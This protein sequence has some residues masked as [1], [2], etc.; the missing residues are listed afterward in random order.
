MRTWVIIFFV[1]LVVQLFGQGLGFDFRRI[2]ST[3]G[4]PSDNM[5]YILTDSDGYLWLQGGKGLCRFDGYHFLSLPQKWPVSEGLT[6]DDAGNIVCAVGVSGLFRLY[7]KTMRLDTLLAGDV[8]NESRV[9]DHFYNPIFYKKEGSIWTATEGHLRQTVLESGKM[10]LFPFDFGDEVWHQS[11][12]LLHDGTLYFAAWSG[13]FRYSGSGK[14]V[15]EASFL[16][17][18]LS[19]V[20]SGGGAIWVASS[21]GKLLQYDPIRRSSRV[22]AS[23]FS[24][25]R[26]LAFGLDPQG[27]AA[28]WV[29]HSNGLSLYY[30]ADDEVRN[31]VYFQAS[32]IIVNQVLLDTVSNSIWLATND[33]LY[34]REG[35]KSVVKIVSLPDNCPKPNQVNAI[36]A[37]K[38]LGYY[39]LGLSKGGVWR[40]DAAK[41]K[42]QMFGFPR[43]VSANSLTAIGDDIWA[44]TTGGVFV[45]RKHQSHFEAVLPQLSDKSIRKVYADTH[46][47]LWVLVRG[48][49]GFLLYQLSTLKPITLPEHQKNPHYSPHQLEVFD[50]AEDRSGR[51]WLGAE[52]CLYWMQSDSFF[53]VRGEPYPLQSDYIMSLEPDSVGIWIGGGGGANY[54]PSPTIRPLPYLKTEGF[55]SD[56]YQNIAIEGHNIVWISTPEGVLRVAVDR[57]KEDALHHYT[58]FSGLVGLPTT[59]TSTALL[60]TPN[61]L[62][63]VGQKNGFGI[64]DS[65]R[66]GALP[67]PDAPKISH[68]ILTDTDTLIWNPIKLQLNESQRSFEVFFTSLNYQPLATT[69]QYRLTPLETKWHSTTDKQASAVYNGLS[70]GDYTLE[71]CT[72]DSRK[73]WSPPNRFAVNIA[74][75]WHETTW[76]KSLFLTL[77]FGF[78]YFLYQFRMYQISRVQRMRNQ[79]SSDLH[80]D[81]GATLSNVNILTTLVRR[82]LPAEHET[83][84]NLHRIEEE[85]Q[86]AGESLDDIIWSINPNHDTVADI[87]ARMRRFA[88]EIFDA[89]DI[90]ANI[91]I[92]GEVEKTRIGMHRRRDI[93]LCYKEAINNLAKYA[94][95]TKA[96]IDIRLKDKNLCIEVK[97]NGVGFDTTQTRRGNGLSNMEKRSLKRGGTVSINSVLGKGTTVKIVIP[98]RRW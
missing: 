58:V 12:F 90:V 22:V 88:T 5:Q 39:W 43:E 1:G 9:E 40:W 74:P 76:A 2:G 15:A 3:D 16:G 30:P 36:I 41:N 6:M 84:V 33:G 57:T 81:I 69:Y 75:K 28:V 38:K 86:N 51:L 13:L 24:G 20:C 4:L 83:Q 42:F 80:D 95:C 29:G 18:P 17:V 63:Y 52:H 62:V 73:I 19:A 55:A 60:A 64:I 10:T 70:Y 37:D 79:I 49:K 59:H 91:S 77:F 68:A 96:H 89:K 8:Y 45:L 14:W 97:D 92:A 50:V 94:K 85:I 7:P 35:S 56:Q 48:E 67:I 11:S 82:K 32:G 53:S 78:I 46:G 27:Q 44:A 66:F 34:H 65:K 87:A 21:D 25:V 23:G 93:W 71:V 47:R 26:S 72:T 31:D 54:V 61:G 98:V